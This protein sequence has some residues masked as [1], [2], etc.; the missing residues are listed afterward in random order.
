MSTLQ[1]LTDRGLIKP[2]RWLPGSVQY[3]TI[4]GSMAYGV[5]DR[6]RL[7]LGSRHVHLD[8]DGRRYR[9]RTCDAPQLR[10]PDSRDV[11]RDPI[12]VRKLGGSRRAL[13][14]A[15]TSSL[16]SAWSNPVDR[17][18]VLDGPHR[19]SGTRATQGDRRGSGPRPISAT[20]SPPSSRSWRRSMPRGKLQPVPDEDRIRSLLLNCLEDHYGR[21]EDCVVNPDRAVA[22]LRN[23]QAELEKVRDLL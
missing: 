11:D 10:V 15:S 5:S 3:E 2:P 12:R 16:S 8:A 1:R 17:S 9:V 7:W 21:L 18:L 6:D 14:P 19:P 23:V 4:M 22:A 20:G 13:R